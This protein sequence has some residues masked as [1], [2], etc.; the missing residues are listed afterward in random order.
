MKKE[1]VPWGEQEHLNCEVPSE[2]ESPKALQTDDLIYLREY[3]NQVVISAFAGRKPESMNK[4][5][6][7]RRE[8]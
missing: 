6:K 7:E 8:S 3:A 4:Q 2:H 1:N 5:I